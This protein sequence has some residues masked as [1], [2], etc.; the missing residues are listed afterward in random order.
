MSPQW[1]RTNVYVVSMR[2]PAIGLNL[3]KRQD[4]TPEGCDLFI[5]DFIWNMVQKE[6][7]T[8]SFR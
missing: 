6:G 7:D 5:S 1:L 3:D 4:D 2:I 8:T